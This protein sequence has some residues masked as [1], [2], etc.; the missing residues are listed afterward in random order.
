MA[1]VGKC[2]DA[3]VPHVGGTAAVGADGNGTRCKH[4]RL[5]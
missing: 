5:K 1:L 2:V 4:L 3:D